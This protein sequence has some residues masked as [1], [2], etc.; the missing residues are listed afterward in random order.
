[1]T[2][3]SSDHVLVGP[4]RSKWPAEAGLSELV[5][6]HLI[7]KDDNGCL[8]MHDQMRDMA[9]NLLEKRQEAGSGVNS[10]CRECCMPRTRFWE[11]WKED[12]SEWLAQVRYHTCPVFRKVDV[13][14]TILNCAR[15]AQGVPL[16]G[17]PT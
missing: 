1:M 15:H 4:F 9:R 8:K 10:R 6:R 17:F 7:S 5:S 11:D 2:S 3:Y 12:A 16:K 13:S 14:H